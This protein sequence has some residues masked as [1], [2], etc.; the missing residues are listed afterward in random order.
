MS[1][2]RKEL[3]SGTAEVTGQAPT[4]TSPA[5]SEEVTGQAPTTKSPA[6]SE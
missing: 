2:I 3:A 1:S 5:F 6:F 4:T